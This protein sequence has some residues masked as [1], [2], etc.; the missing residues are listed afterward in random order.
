M[1]LTHVDPICTYK[2]VSASGNAPMIV[3]KPFWTSVNVL[4]EALK[5]ALLSWVILFSFNILYHVTCS[6]IICVVS[7]HPQQMHMR[8]A[9]T[10]IVLRFASLEYGTFLKLFLATSLDI[11]IH[12]YRYRYIYIS[13]QTTTITEEEN[14]SRTSLWAKAGNARRWMWSNFVA[15][16][17]ANTP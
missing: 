7:F 14:A 17:Y 11:D 3:V 6:T 9:W 5:T 8:I 2:L 15:I 16:A 10:Y 13:K 4:S 1:V 12:R